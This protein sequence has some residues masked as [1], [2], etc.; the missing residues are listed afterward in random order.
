MSQ[1]RATY[2]MHFDCYEAV[3]QMVSEELKA[4]LA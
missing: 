4:S 3:P 2:S 1:G